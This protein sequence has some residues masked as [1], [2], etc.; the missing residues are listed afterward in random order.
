VKYDAGGAIC[1]FMF[2]ALM[3]G[4]VNLLLLHTAISL[5]PFVALF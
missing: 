2:A 3:K 4:W 5:D 1:F